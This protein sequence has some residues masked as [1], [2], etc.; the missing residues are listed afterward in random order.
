[1]TWARFEQSDI[2]D[3]S[4][5]GDT[6]PDTGAGM[7]LLL[8]LG[9]STGVQVVMIRACNEGYPKIPEVFT[10]TEKARTRVC[11]PPTLRKKTLVDLN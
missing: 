10:I 7:P 5:Y 6:A 4:L 11:P 1:M 3:P 8:V 9:Y 2:N